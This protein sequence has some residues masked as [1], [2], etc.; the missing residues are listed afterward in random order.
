MLLS[1]ADGAPALLERTFKGSK[2]GR[3]LLWTTPLSRRSIRSDRGAWNEFPLPAGNT[4]AFLALMNETVPYLAGTSNEQLD[5]EAGSNV[6]LFLGT[7]ARYQSCLLI[8]P[9]TKTPESLTPP[10]TSEYLEILTP[11]ML[12]QWTVMARDA[13]NRQT[14]LGFSINPPRAESRFDRLE[15]QDLDA[16]FGKDSYALAEDA[17]SL[18]KFQDTVRVGNELFPWLMMLILIIVTLENLLANTFYKEAP[19]PVAAG[20]SA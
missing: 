5:F 16:I 18:K 2:T 9:D 13:E 20:A 12:G 3:V 4:W 14:Q 1:Y 7:G 8:G 11:Q 15:T 10:A 19:R 17:A 6:S